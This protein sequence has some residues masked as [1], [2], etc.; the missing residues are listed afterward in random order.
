[1]KK[2]VGIMSILFC[3]SFFSCRFEA[4]AAEDGSLKINT[5]IQTTPQSSGIH[6]IE[7]E[8]DLSAL[9]R[10][11]TTASIQ[12][13]QDKTKKEEQQDKHNLFIK[14]RSSQRLVDTYTAHLFNTNTAVTRTDNQQITLNMPSSSFSVSMIVMLL[15]AGLVMGYSVI[16]MMNAKKGQDR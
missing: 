11:E 10:L 6:Y 12:K 13:Q 7:Q 2:I 14:T 9:F 4:L 3:L 5:N 8:S 16:R 15:V 1:M